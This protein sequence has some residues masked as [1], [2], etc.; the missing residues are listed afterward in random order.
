MWQDQLTAGSTTACVD[1]PG[2]CKKARCARASKQCPSKLSESSSCSGSLSDG[3]CLGSV[4]WL[5]LFVTATKGTLSTLWVRILPTARLGHT[6][7][8]C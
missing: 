1:C 5:E 8:S 3:V 7:S 4:I 6:P 2:M